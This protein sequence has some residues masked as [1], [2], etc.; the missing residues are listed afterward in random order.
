M[1]VVVP[2]KRKTPRTACSERRTRVLPER[3][4]AMAHRYRPFTIRLDGDAQP[5]RPGAR[6]TEEATT[7]ATVRKTAG[8]GASGHIS[9]SNPAD[10]RGLQRREP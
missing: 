10:W 7:A 9:P 6:G 5:V 1:S 4:R 8:Q 2:D 3:G